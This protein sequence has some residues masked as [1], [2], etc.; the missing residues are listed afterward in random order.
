MIIAYIV[1]KWIWKLSRNQSNPYS[2]V[3]P[4][5]SV[6][7]RLPSL[8][9]K[10]SFGENYNLSYDYETDTYRYRDWFSDRIDAICEVISIGDSSSIQYLYK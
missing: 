7:N 5:I 8:F 6:H 2:L 9:V 1:R 3:S 10:P 4:I